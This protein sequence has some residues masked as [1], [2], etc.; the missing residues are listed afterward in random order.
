MFD[1]DSP[2]GWHEYEFGA[3][4]DLWINVTGTFSLSLSEKDMSDP[5]GLC[6]MN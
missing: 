3:F 1:E 6:M 5:D 2:N 4:V